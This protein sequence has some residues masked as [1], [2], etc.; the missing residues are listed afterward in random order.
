MDIISFG[1]TDPGKRRNNNE[2]A[3]LRNDNLLL[4]AVADGIGGNAGGEVASRIAV[5]TIEE[6]VTGLLGG[7]DAAFP[8]NLGAHADPP[9][10]ALREAINLANQK[11]LR[12]SIQNPALLGMG[13]TLT[14]AF[15]RN[16]HVLIANIGDSRAYLFRSGT[17]KQLTT[18][19]SFVAER[20]ASGMLTPQEAKLSPYRHVITRALGIDDTVRPDFTE[21][22][23][24]QDDLVLLCTDGLTEM[25]E[26]SDIQHILSVSPNRNVVQALLAAANDRGG[27]D[28][29]TTVVMWIKE[30]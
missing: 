12:S 9:L 20:V 21:H 29:I 8:P 4:Y 5:E 24:H 15:F 10:F 22:A 11:I 13:T 30:V 26:D 27:V 17:L 3:Y 19:H 25:L 16:N 23:V 7:K 14:A 1:G 2:D 6:T 28:N 18:D